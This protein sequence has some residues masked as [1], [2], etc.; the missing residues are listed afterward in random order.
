[1]R[2]TSARYRSRSEGKNDSGGGGAGRHIQWRHQT[3]FLGRARSWQI[4]H[5]I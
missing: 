3:F 2:R 4:D 5:G 1:M